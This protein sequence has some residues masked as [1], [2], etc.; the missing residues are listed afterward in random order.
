[1]DYD[2]LGMFCGGGISETPLRGTNIGLTCS[3]T[4]SVVRAR[5]K[6]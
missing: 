5:G 6:P 4:L 3:V 2:G 1:M